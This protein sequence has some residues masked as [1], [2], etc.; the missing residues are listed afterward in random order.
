MFYN[1]PEFII[2]RAREL[3]A[4]Q[5]PAEI[6]FWKIIGAKKLMGLHFR[7]QHPIYIY[8]A[9]FYCHSLRL[10]I[11]I[12][13]EIHD[14]KDKY[15]SDLN[16]T[17][18]LE[19]FGITVIRFMNKEIFGNREMVKMRLE[20]VCQELLRNH[21]TGYDNHGIILNAIHYPPTP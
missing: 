9:D 19:R 2:R 11:E 6:E 12:D 15:E 14:E 1:A 4:R 21:E 13:G 20:E 18:E 3:R 17:A 8:I 7:R 10:V 5:T 16:R